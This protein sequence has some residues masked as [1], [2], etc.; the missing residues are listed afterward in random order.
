M[1]HLWKIV[2]PLLAY[3]LV[4]SVL[5][6]AVRPRAGRWHADVWNRWDVMHYLSIAETGYEVHPCELHDEPALWGNAGW[7]P[8]YSLLIRIVIWTGLKSLHAA[9]LVTAL[10]RRVYLRRWDA[11]FS[12]QAQY[13]QGLHNPLQTLSRYLQPTRW[14]SVR[15]MPY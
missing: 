10:A 6:A 8:G 4:Q 5:L 15:G 12:I 3:L 1:R 2:P 7:L 14:V 11:F 13:G 9:L